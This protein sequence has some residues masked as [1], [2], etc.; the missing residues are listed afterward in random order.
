MIIFQWEYPSPWSLC[1]TM[2]QSTS[3]LFHGDADASPR[4]QLQVCSLNSLLGPGI[5]TA[6]GIREESQ[7]HSSQKPVS[8]AGIT[9]DRPIHQLPWKSA[10][11]CLFLLL[12]NYFGGHF[13]PAWC[14]EDRKICKHMASKHKDPNYRLI[15]FTVNSFHRCEAWSRWSLSPR[16]NHGSNWW[17]LLWKFQNWMY[18]ISL[19]I[20]NLTQYTL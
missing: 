13:F 16:T 20:L 17:E 14:I 18:M 15:V 7:V 9:E 5:N 6:I 11:I 10:L 3:P 12:N 8:Q 1:N 19:K 2:R 4:F